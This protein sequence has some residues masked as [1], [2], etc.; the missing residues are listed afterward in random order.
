MDDSF[1][2]AIRLPKLRQVFRDCPDSID[3]ENGNYIFGRR[4]SFILGPDAGRSRGSL[5]L[6]NEVRTC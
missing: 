3:S 5:T 1:H 4:Y 2:T 6:M